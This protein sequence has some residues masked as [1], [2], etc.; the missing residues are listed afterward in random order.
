MPLSDHVSSTFSSLKMFA[1]ILLEYCMAT[2]EIVGMATLEIVGMATLE[3]VG[4]ATLQIVGMATLQ[5]VGMAT[6]EIGCGCMLKQ[7]V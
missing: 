4:M 3:I 6:I 1:L 2:L 7:L 5:I